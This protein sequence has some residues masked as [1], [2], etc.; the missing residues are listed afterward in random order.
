MRCA[1]ALG[2]ATCLTGRLR[3]IH[4]H[5]ALLPARVTV[6]RNARLAMQDTTTT[7]QIIFAPPAIILASLVLAEHQATA[8]HAPLGICSIWALENAMF[9]RQ[10]TTIRM[11][12]G[13]SSA[14]DAPQHMPIVLFALLEAVRSAWHRTE[15]R[16]EAVRIVLALLFQMVQFPATPARTVPHRRA[17]HRRKY[18][19]CVVLG[20]TTLGT[21]AT[22]ATAAV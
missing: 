16:A 18:V 20:I 11:A 13:L 4:V 10:G 17:A 9:A 14:R 5:N 1:L 2:Q 8:S 22:R 15:C 3:A 21:N 7:L 12:L 6:A 19:A